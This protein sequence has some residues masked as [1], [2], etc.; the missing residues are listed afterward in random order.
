MHPYIPIVAW[1]RPR[2]SFRDYDIE[3]IM[4]FPEFIIPGI[5]YRWDN[6]EDIIEEVVA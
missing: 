4:I 3:E 1:H 5:R 6:I 2:T